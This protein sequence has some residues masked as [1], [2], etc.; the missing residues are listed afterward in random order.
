MLKQ[1]IPAF[2]KKLKLNNDARQIANNIR[3]DSKKSIALL[4]RDNFKL[5]QKVFE[6][7]YKNFK[8]FNKIA[9]QEMGIIYEGFYSEAVEE[10]IEALT[11]YQ[12]LSKDKSRG[13][14]KYIKAT[15]EHV[16]AGICD[17]TGEL[18]RK[19]VNMAKKENL[20]QLEKFYKTIDNIA[21]DL[22]RIGFRGKLRHKYDEVER[23]LRRMEQ[24]LYDIRLKR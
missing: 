14:P 4:R 9:K 3:I 1:A 7:I 2:F 6:V 16:I 11:F 23:N 18:V 12:F 8:N 21:E 10:Y 20:K 22:T 5:V 13:M 15:P 19:S 17:F 24:I